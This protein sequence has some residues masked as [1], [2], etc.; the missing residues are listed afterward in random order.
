MFILQFDCAVIFAVLAIT[1]WLWFLSA[2][3]PTVARRTG[4]NPIR[5]VVLA[6]SETRKNVVRLWS[7][8]R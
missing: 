6:A 3:V 4:G 1:V 5:M 7:M 2:V 8:L